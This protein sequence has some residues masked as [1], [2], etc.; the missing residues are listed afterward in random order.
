M[1]DLAS[2]HPVQAP[3]SAAVLVHLSWLDRFLPLWILLAMAGG[4]LL[5][6]LVPGLQAV[7]GAVQV[8]HTSLPI[9]LGLLL[10]MYPVLAKVRYGELGHMARDRRL[11]TLTLG[12][13]WGPGPPKSN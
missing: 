12:L 8:D 1:A 13:T 2:E 6:R 4:L 11:L 10:M 9:A 3:Q 5:G 7:L